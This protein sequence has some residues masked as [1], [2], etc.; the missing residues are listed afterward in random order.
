[1]TKPETMTGEL[2]ESIMA[3][4]PESMSQ[5]QLAAFIMLLVDTYAGPDPRSGA[6]LLL[7][8]TVTYNRTCGVPDARTAAFLI[9]TAEHLK[10]EE[11][12]KK[13]M[14]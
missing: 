7:T 4:M 9:G 14:H 13:K 8:T 2:I 6:S 5:H 11:P 1:M 10:N 12:F 3:Q